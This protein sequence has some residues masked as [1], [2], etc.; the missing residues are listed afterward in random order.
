MPVSHDGASF[1]GAQG[2][3]GRSNNHPQNSNSKLSKTNGS[4]P[5]SIDDMPFL[6]RPN[7][8]ENGQVKNPQPDHE[9]VAI[10]GIGIRLPG[11]IHTTEEFWDVLYNGKDMRGLIPSNRFNIDGYDTTIGKKSAIKTHFGYF[12]EDELAC[13]DASFFNISKPELEKVDPQQRQILEV[14]RECLENA[15]EIDYRGKMI[16]CYVGTFGED[17]LQSQSKENQFTGGK[18]FGIYS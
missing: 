13:L 3:N 2:N 15:G 10:C 12:L 7:G 18:W 8:R 1:N 14:T 6:A 4:A 16:G 11:G 5:I 9:P 17:W